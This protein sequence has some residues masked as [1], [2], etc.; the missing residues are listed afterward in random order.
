MRTWVRVLIYSAVFCLLLSAASALLHK[1]GLVSFG[2]ASTLVLA[3]FGFATLVAVCSVGTLFVSIL[4]KQP[5]GIYT[6]FMAFLVCFCLAG[7]GAILYNKTVV[8]PFIHNASTD[9]EDPPKF[10]D[11][12][13]GRRGNASNPVEMNEFTINSHRESLKDLKPLVVN[14]SASL[15]YAA[16]LELVEDRGWHIVNQ[17]PE[18]GLIEATAE[19][20]WFGFKDDIA[21]RVRGDDAASAT[22]IDLHSVSRIGQTD[23]GV[24][25]AR[26]RSYLDDLAG[27]LPTT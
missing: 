1:F 26:I 10:T 25:A 23:L 16:A 7:Y 12:I 13:M 15:A 27:R 5:Y 20:F 14:T 8:N 22:T 2:F 6:M 24:N 18:N 9:I 11:A 21:I 3:S 19:T 17:A 4:R